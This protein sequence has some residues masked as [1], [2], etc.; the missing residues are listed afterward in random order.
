MEQFCQDLFGHIARFVPDERDL[1]FISKKFYQFALELP[2]IGIWRKYKSDLDVH[3]FVIKYGSNK[4]AE[5]ILPDK[6]DILTAIDCN[7]IAIIDKCLDIHEYY[8]SEIGN[9]LLPR[10]GKSEYVF[11]R[12]FDGLHLNK[13][14]INIVQWHLFYNGEI[15]AGDK[16]RRIIESE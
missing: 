1:L 16:V 5:L 10:I 4:M 6:M 11:R 7:N 8:L 2:D 15:E 14:E 12:V 3:G 9:M 13:Y